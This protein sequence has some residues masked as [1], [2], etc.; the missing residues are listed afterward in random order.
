MAS[1]SLYI[2]QLLAG[3]PVV[4]PFASMIGMSSPKS[5][6]GGLAADLGPVFDPCA[7]RP[8]A[9]IGMPVVGTSRRPAAGVGAPWQT[10]RKHWFEMTGLMSRQKSMLTAV[11]AGLASVTVNAISREPPASVAPSIA[12]SP[13]GS[14]AFC[15]TR[16]TSP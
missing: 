12:R 6:L 15:G 4:L 3:L 13:F 5:R 1:K 7:T 9:V 2:S 14:A 16:I 11:G 8:M 10:P